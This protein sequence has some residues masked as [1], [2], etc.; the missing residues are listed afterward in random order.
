MKK[1]NVFFLTM[2]IFFLLVGWYYIW[3]A[4]IHNVE[5]TFFLVLDRLYLGAIIIVALFGDKFKWK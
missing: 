1:K 3:E 4:H 2:G 5:I